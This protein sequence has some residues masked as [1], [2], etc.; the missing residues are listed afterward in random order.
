MITWEYMRLIDTARSD[1]EAHTLRELNE[2]GRARWE[3]VA[4]EPAEARHP[5][6]AFADRVFWLKRSV[7]ATQ[8]ADE[9]E[10]VDDPDDPFRPEHA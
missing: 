5:G 9:P 6:S 7:E 2:L 1:A 3:L 10:V 8:L 4:V